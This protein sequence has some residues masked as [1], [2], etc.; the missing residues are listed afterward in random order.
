MKAARVLFVLL[1]SLLSN[2]VV[3]QND[4]M[5]VVQGDSVIGKHPVSSYD[6]IVFYDPNLSDTS[7]IKDVDGNVYTSVKIGNQEWMAENLRTSKYSD[8]TSI[9]SIYG[10]DIWM[11]LT[12]GAWCNKFNESQYDSIY[13]K[14]YNW[15][16][17]ETGKLC[18]TGW[19]VP[20]DPEW[21]ALTDYLAA[22]GHD[23]KEATALKSISEWAY[24]YLENMNGTDDYGWNALPGDALGWYYDIE[25]DYSF[26]GWENYG[27]AWWSSS[28]TTVDQAWSRIFYSYNDVVSRE[29]NL[30][31]NGYSVRCLRD[32]ERAVM[33]LIEGG[34]VIGEYAT[35]TVD[36]IIFYNPSS[37][38]TTI[39]DTISS[40][41]NGEGVIDID[42]NTYQS[43]IIGE[44]EWMSENLRTTKYSDGNVIPNVTGN[45]EWYNLSTGAW[46]HYFNNS[47]HDTI[48]GKL[49]NWYAVETEKLCPIG[50]HVPT[51]AEWTL[52]TD[53]LTANGHT[54]VEGKAL[55]ATSGW[56]NDGNGKDAFE[57]LGLPGGARD[58]YGVFYS[59]GYGGNWWSSSLENI[60]NGAW[61][62]YLAHNSDEVHR[63]GNY[64]VYGYS[65][66]CLRD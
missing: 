54:E 49:Y 12:T 19:H 7:I 66:R 22:N 11:D 47:Q 50:W 38:D 62:L 28:D 33:Y 41:Q 48:Y 26:M 46:C 60:S 27:G 44:Q 53:Y 37:L 24:D 5:Y 55:K 65:V 35:S 6:S 59:I 3:S 34:E 56:N 32:D 4:T 20:T 23:G 9:D 42:G 8:G 15:Y 64:K 14:L 45:T 17:V 57:W 31:A 1:L 43:V 16:A 52:L 30:A 58:N 13:G 29:H 39:T 40:I 2:A 10:G 36:S 18:P 25:W 21:T 51:D 63:F 61:S